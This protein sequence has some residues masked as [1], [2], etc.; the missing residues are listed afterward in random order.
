MG[1]TS[2]HDIPLDMSRQRLR[3]SPHLGSIPIRGRNLD[4]GLYISLKERQVKGNEPS[5]SK[6]AVEW[7][8]LGIVLA[9]SDSCDHC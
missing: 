2:L 8:I 6:V 7:Y 1:R 3:C 4:D 9:E 5:G